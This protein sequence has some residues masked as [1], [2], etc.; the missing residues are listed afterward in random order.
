MVDSAEA[1]WARSEKGILPPSNT[2]V[3]SCGCLAVICKD[4]FVHKIIFIA[5]AIH[6]IYV[7]KSFFS[8]LDICRAQY[9][10]ERLGRKTAS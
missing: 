4:I 3:S 6:S 2:Q 10:T 1:C 7:D 9:A 8:S 5:L